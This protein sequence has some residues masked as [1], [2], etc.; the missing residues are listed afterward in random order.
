MKIIWVWNALYL[1]L[2]VLADGL[3]NIQP[4]GWGPLGGYSYIKLY[5]YYY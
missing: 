3:Y 4:G 5:Y 1:F 2:S